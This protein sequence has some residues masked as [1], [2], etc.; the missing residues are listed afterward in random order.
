MKAPVTWRGRSLGLGTGGYRG[1]SAK[2]SRCYS[3]ISSAFS[4]STVYVYEARPARATSSSSQQ[5]LRT[6]GRWPSWSRCPGPH[7][8]RQSQCS[9]HYND[10]LQSFFNEIGLN[11]LNFLEQRATRLALASTL[12]RECVSGGVS[13]RLSGPDFVCA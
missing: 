2:R 6:F 5:P 1:G 3:R 7:R 10:L 11:R 12:P 13:G 8:N 4:S 9:R